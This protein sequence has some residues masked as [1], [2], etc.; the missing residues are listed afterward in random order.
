MS[1][2]A[3]EFADPS[4]LLEVQNLNKKFCQDIRHNMLYGIG[5]IGRSVVGYKADYARL[6]AKEFWALKNINFQLREG[7][8]LGV[9][10]ANGSGKTSLMRLVGNIYPVE[11][12]T[13]YARPGIKVTSV[14]ALHSGMQQLYTGREN[15][16][17][18]GA[19][20]GMSREQIQEKLDFII[21][22][23]ELGDRIDN[24]LGNY[25]SGMRARLAYAIALATDPD[26]FLL[27]EALAVGDSVFKTK[28]FENLKSWVKMPG[29]GVLFVSNNV[30]KILKVANRTLVMEKGEIIHDSTDI[31]EA[32]QFYIIN[33]LKDLDEASRQRKLQ[34]VMDYDF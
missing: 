28:C 2:T 29:R 16:F 20:Y 31:S 25:S 26:I 33:C 5:D 23:S 13:I 9:V 4:V 32:L 30:R 27:D 24:P 8:I 11:S 14:F 12:G 6:R 22:F 3:K 17:L 1:L 21:N 18:K 19:L 34:K 15:V 10:G 7:E